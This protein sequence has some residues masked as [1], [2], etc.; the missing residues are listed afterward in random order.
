VAGEEQPARGCAVGDTDDWKL[1]RDADGAGIDNYGRELTV[2]LFF[3]EVLGTAEDWDGTN[4]QA[5]L[6]ALG[7]LMIDLADACDANGLRVVQ[8]EKVAW[9]NDFELRCVDDETG[10]KGYQLAVRLTTRV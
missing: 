10:R 7:G 2:G 9:D 6:D 8:L 4:R 5:F 1:M 3:W